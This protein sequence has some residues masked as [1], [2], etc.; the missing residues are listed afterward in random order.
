MTSSELKQNR[1]NEMNGW[2]DGKE[3]RKY[4]EIKYGWKEGRKNVRKEGR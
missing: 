2:M 4:K 1:E 3:G